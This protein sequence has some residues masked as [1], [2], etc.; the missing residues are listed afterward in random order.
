MHGFYVYHITSPY[1]WVQSLAYK[2]CSHKHNGHLYIYAWNVCIA[3]EIT[4]YTRLFRVG[5]KA[6]EKMETH[7]SA[8][9]DIYTVGGIITQ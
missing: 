7:I 1:I 2:K 3:I 6:K 8:V 4:W 5:L 9:H